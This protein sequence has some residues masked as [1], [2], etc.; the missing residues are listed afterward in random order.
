MAVVDYQQDYVIRK[1]NVSGSYSANIHRILGV[2]YDGLGASGYGGV[3]YGDMW[4]VGLIDEAYAY[5]LFEERILRFSNQ[6]APHDLAD[7]LLTCGTAG[8]TVAATWALI[9]DGATGVTIGST[10][11]D[12]EDLDFSS[13]TTMEGIA[14]VIQNGIRAESLQNDIHVRYDEANTLFLMWSP[15]ATVSYLTAG[16]S[17]TDISGAGYMNGLTGTGTLAAPLIISVV[18]RPNH[19]SDSL[20]DWFFDRYS[21]GI[22]YGALAELLSMPGMPW[23]A[24]EKAGY[25]MGQYK[26][27]RSDAKRENSQE[28]RGRAP[29]LL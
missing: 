18:F 26:L 3:N 25:W 27:F 23:T 10:S 17:G 7:R 11:Y 15:S 5:S 29:G 6:Y 8:E 4:D 1:G 12:V 22:A 9:S 21:Y 19:N 20:P 13:E 16:A 2:A 14:R 24:A 28:Y